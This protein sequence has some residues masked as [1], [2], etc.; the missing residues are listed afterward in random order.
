M[1]LGILILPLTSHLEKQLLKLLS[2]YCSV[3]VVDFKFFRVKRAR[4]AKPCFFFFF[5]MSKA[6]GYKANVPG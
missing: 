5:V 4:K 3:A 6:G 1:R 2:F